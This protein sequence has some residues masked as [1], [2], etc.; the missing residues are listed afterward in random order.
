MTSDLMQPVQPRK[1]YQIWW[2]IWS[3]PGTEAFKSLLSEPGKS[4]TR[5]FIWVAVTTLIAVL[6]TTLFSSLVM[7]DTMSGLFTNEELYAAIGGFTIYSLCIVILSPIFA[8][9]GI[10]VAAA[11]YHWIAGFFHGHGTW[12]DMVLCLSAVSAPAG[13]ISG[14]I[15]LF[16]LL[17]FNNPVLFFLPTLVS[18]A[19][20]IYAVILNVNAIKASEDVGTWGALAAMFI[21][22]IIVVAITICCSLTILIPIMTTTISGQ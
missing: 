9:I 12:S 5:G 3:H 2:D 6:I 18:L 13:L 19:F 4:S 11:I 14:V 21:P 20:G 15:G 17:L 7:R 22:A 16:S 1:W 8:V 10:A